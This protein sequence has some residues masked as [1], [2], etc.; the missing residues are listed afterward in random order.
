MNELEA[1][2]RP[3]FKSGNL[4]NVKNSQ[5]GGHMKVATSWLS[6][7]WGF[8]L[9]GSMLCN[10]RALQHFLDLEKFIRKDEFIEKYKNHSSFDK[11]DVCSSISNLYYV[12]WIFD[13]EGDVLSLCVVLRWFMFLGKT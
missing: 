10:R 2:N 7:L 4:G 1:I 13:I 9:S 3:K 12:L 6:S 5:N 11:K 8:P